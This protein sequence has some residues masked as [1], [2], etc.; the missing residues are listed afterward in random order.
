MSNPVSGMYEAAANLCWQAIEF[1]DGST[2]YER[3]TVAHI[4]N[5]TMPSLNRSAQLTSGL[6]SQAA[7]NQRLVQ[8]ITESIEALNEVLT[9][10]DG[11]TALEIST[12]AQASGLLDELYASLSQLGIR[13][14]LRKASYGK[15]FDFRGAII[16]AGPPTSSSSNS[17]SS[18]SSSGCYIAT[19][20]YGSYDCPQV[21]VLRRYRD[22]ALACSSVGRA[23][24]KFYYAVSPTLVRLLGRYKSV[25]AFNRLWLNRIVSRLRQSGY[26]DAPYKD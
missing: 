6:T 5:V 26:S 18:S 4:K 22:N 24:V 15:P 3:K 7:T 9:A 13:A 23:F 2:E 1:S 8:C 25:N 11:S 17:S 12:I 19:S 10:L 14:N 20:A 16:K 21:W